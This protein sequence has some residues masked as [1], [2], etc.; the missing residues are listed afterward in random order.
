MAEVERALRVAVVGCGAAGCSCAW[1]LLNYDVGLGRPVRVTLFDGGRGPGGRAATRRPAEVPGLAVDHGPPLFHVVGDRGF[2]GWAPHNSVLT[3]LL[4]GLFQAGALAPW[5]GTFGQVAADRPLWGAEGHSSSFRALGGAEPDRELRRAMGLLESNPVV[6][7]RKSTL[8]DAFTRERFV[9]R[10]DMASLGGAILREAEAS[11]GG[12][13]L[14]ARYGTRVGG[15]ARGAEG[16]WEL[17]GPGDA[18][19]GVYDWVVVTSAPGQGRGGAMRQVAETAGSA[20]LLDRTEAVA[21]S[22]N[23]E[24]AHVAMLAWAAA[25]GDAAPGGRLEALGRLFDITELVEA[26]PDPDEL[27]G[28]GGAD[29]SRLESEA[30]PILG[31]LPKAPA[32]RATLRPATGPL[33]AVVR[34]SL[35]PPHAVV[36]L[37]STAEFSARHPAVLGSEGSAAR[38]GAAAGDPAEEARVGAELY[39][40]FEQLLQEALGAEGPLPA[41]TWG[42]VVHRWAAAVTDIEPPPGP[43]PLVFAEVRVAIAGDFLAPPGAPRAGRDGEGPSYACVEN[44]LASGLAAAGQLLAAAAAAGPAGEA[45]SKL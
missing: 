30:G 25:E 20:A 33:A 41:P 13:A 3:P 15:F 43:E 37:Q 28:P 29:P 23:S 26:D 16:E 22:L 11:G 38:N 45:A 9:A 7:L 5:A 2:F 18:P 19:L 6:S 21:A 39:R 35:G 42:P 34:Q 10:P 27:D 1:G 40:A 8:R 32:V 14:V 44:A 12:G 4:N 36:V 31:R 24:S 17:R